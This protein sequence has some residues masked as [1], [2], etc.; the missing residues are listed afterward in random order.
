MA[1][2]STFGHLS[3]EGAFLLPFLEMATSFGRFFGEGDQSN[4]LAMH[5]GG[6]QR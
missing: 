2:I 3:D 6:A 5:L 4:Q 1:T